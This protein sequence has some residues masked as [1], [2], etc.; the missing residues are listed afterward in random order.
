M[1]DSE[2]TKE[3]LLEELLEM[4][5]QLADAKHTEEELSL[6]EAK[7]HRL[8]QSMMDAFVSVDLDG[9]IQE[10]NE[11]Y[12]KMLGYEEQELLALRFTD[13]TPEKWH[14]FQ[15]EILEKQVLQRGYSDIYEKEYR[16][17]DG[18]IFPIELRTCL[19]T[20]V[21]NRPCGMWAIIR[22]IT[23]RKRAEEALQ[24]ANDELERNVQERTAELRKSEERFRSYFVQG[25]IGMAVS[26]ADMR[27]VEVNDRFC[28]IFGYSRD[29]I[30]QQKITDYT[31]PD[32]LTAFLSSY[33]QM[34]SGEI[35]HYTVDR[36]YVRKDGKV[37]YLTIFAK[38]FRSK[39][40]KLDH[41]LALI[42]DT[43]ER[44]V[45]QKALRQSYEELE[46]IYDGM[47]DGILIA[48]A[49]AVHPIRANPAYCR[50]I[51]WPPEEVENVSPEM[52]HPP[53]VMPRVLKHFEEI[54]RGQIARLENLPFLRK[55]GSIVYADVVSNQ[56]QYNERPCWI[57][58]FHDITERVQ[59]EEALRASESQYRQIFE[60]VNDALFIF[61]YDG[62]IVAANPAACATY[63]YS[64]EEIIGLSVFNLL[65][66]DYHHCFHECNQQ[67]EKGESFYSES[68]DLRKDGTPFHVEVRGSGFVFRGKPHVLA[69]MRNID[70]RKRA[71]EARQREFRTLKYLLQSSDHER[72]TIAYEI[73]DGLAQYLAA[74]IM[75]FDVYKHLL[76]EKSNDA[77]KAYEGAMTLLQQSHYEAR[78]LIAGVRPPV[79]DE[80]GVVEAI[81]HLINEQNRRKGPK[82][83]F[84]S[85]VEFSR[86]VPILENA[87]YRICQEGLSNACQ[88]SQS[89][90]TLVELRQLNDRIRIKI[91]D[92]GTGFNPKK[93]KE[94]CYGLIGIRERVRLLGGKCKIQSLAQRGTRIRVELPLLERVE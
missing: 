17:K 94:N 19:I 44:I 42:D 49:K 23:E 56:I 11:S 47:A 10:C 26:T 78:R 46:A 4:R 71:E 45:A 65:R 79:L 60:S 13:L 66:P 84:H 62:N 37:I 41:L 30:L 32:D 1:I 91:R 52:V 43:T 70:E 54:E 57:S 51:D 68:I 88:H 73:H 74:A 31:H 27:W 76:E 28:E 59:A 15:R 58:F 40:G 81:A 9:R 34:L 16:K 36:R 29:E 8:H 24:K 90:R 55:D 38:A 39:E 64:T 61:D 21:Q 67:I 83:E 86:L 3:Q 69:V 20:D 25:L 22:D 5:R 53:E 89:K 93:V 63:G 2:K 18:T 14:S 75:Q 50:M 12:C 85:K 6:S 80:A 87:I 35:D 77:T 33:R 92:W 82:I 48:D 72:Q 7:Y